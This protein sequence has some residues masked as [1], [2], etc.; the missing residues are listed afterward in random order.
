[1]KITRRSTLAALMA[2][3]STL[4]A[5]P[6]HAN[7][8]GRKIVVVGAGLAG[9]AAARALASAG[10]SVTVLE[11]R[12]R[13]GGRVWT[14]RAWTGLPMDMGAS[15]IHGLN[16]NPITE[17]ARQAGAD[18]VETS[19]DADMALDASGSAIDLDEAY[20][21]AEKIMESARRT[22]ERQ[23]HDLSL[24]AAIEA[25]RG[26]SSANEAQRRLVRHVIDGEITT[27]FGSSW[28]ETSA[29]HYDE[30]D[31]F[32]GND[33][34]FPGG[35]DQIISYLAKGLDIRTNAPVTALSPDG[36]GVATTLAG[37]EVLSADHA[38]V[39][40]P[41]GVLKA[42]GLLF[43]EPLS[44]A[45]QKAIEAIGM[46][47]LSKVWF[48]FD[49]I[50][51]PDDVDW[52]EWV[53]PQPGYWSQWL[54]LARIKQVPVLLAFHGGDEARHIEALSDKEIMARADGALKAMFGSSFPAQT[55]T[56]G[57]SLQARPAMMHIPAPHMGRFCRV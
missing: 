36:E 5:Q 8:G 34:V 42:G 26:W 49:E 51:W 38:V 20:D 55:G 23:N 22:S 17:L 27:E 7:S 10:A 25:S 16:G 1:M 35:Y 57:S 19:F 47:L 15:W 54:S 4:I 2:S 46:G 9:L 11:G 56:G 44:I 14:S 50:A 41:L 45:R 52:I 6:V 53:G 13:I 31:V 39:T 3:L 30:G 37:G 40:V 12:E 32:G 33:A 43:A 29:W 48:F 24:Q 28:A 21:L 18:Y